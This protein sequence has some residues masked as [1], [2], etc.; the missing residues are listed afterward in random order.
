MDV[1]QCFLR[2]LKEEGILVV[3]WITGSENDSDMFTKNLDRPL[4][5]KFA[6]VYLGKDEYF[7]STE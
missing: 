6:L 4:F 1:R 2:E 3:K 5:E 7:P